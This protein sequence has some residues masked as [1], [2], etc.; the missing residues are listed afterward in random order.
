MQIDIC[1]PWKG[2]RQELHAQQLSETRSS[3]NRLQKYSERHTSRPDTSLRSVGL[4]HGARAPLCLQSFSGD[5]D[6]PSRLNVTCVVL[7]GFLLDRPFPFIN[8]CFHS[9]WTTCWALNYYLQRVVAPSE[10][11]SQMP[12]RLCDEPLNLKHIS[13][14]EGQS[15]H[16]FEINYMNCIRLYYTLKIGIKLNFFWLI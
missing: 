5:S 4:W 11:S 14:L 16:Y 7:C 3:W 6:A 9:Y 2:S 12:L 15:C 8:T 1:Q 13:N 10:H